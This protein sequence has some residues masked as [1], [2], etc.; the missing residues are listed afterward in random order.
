MPAGL[1]ETGL[2]LREEE[3]EEPAK[4]A[5]VPGVAERKE[6]DMLEGVE[7]ISTLVGCNGQKTMGGINFSKGTM[8][9]KLFASE[10]GL[11]P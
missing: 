2:Q 10:Q 3:K 7:A 5:V 6:E 1:P 11:F 8:D 9:S 4:Q